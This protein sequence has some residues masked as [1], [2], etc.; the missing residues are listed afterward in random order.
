MRR[1]VALSAVPVAIAATSILL[2]G[3]GESATDDTTRD[4]SGAVA[5][6]GT[7]G[8]EKLRVGD[9]LDV[10]EFAQKAEGDVESFTGVPCSD[11]HQAEV[12]VVNKTFYAKQSAKFPGDT[13]LGDLA[14]EACAAAFESFT[15]APYSDKTTTDWITITPTADSWVQDDRTLVC[16]IVTPTAD[17]N[18]LQKTTGSLKG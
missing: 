11:P 6:A 14:D 2:A 17:G 8:V 9:C 5:T 3:C 1:T 4:A 16:A 7:L 10:G 13:A 12:F 15:G 18:D